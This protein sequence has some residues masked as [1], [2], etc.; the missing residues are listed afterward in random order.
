MDQLQTLF[1]GTATQDQVDHINEKLQSL[2][3][4]T[5]EERKVSNV[6]YHILNVTL[7][8]LTNV[9]QALVKLETATSMTEKNI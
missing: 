9:H 6:H 4:F 2:N 7:G 1:F 5:E 3:R 8:D